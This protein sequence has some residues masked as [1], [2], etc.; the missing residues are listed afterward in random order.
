MSEPLSL[1]DLRRKTAIHSVNG[2][3]ETIVIMGL[4]A[5]D[6]C[7]IIDRFQGIGLLSLGGRVN[8]FEALREV[9]SALAAWTAAAC[10]MGGSKEAEQHVLDN[11]T[12]DQAMGIVEASMPLTFVHGG[13]GPFYDRQMAVL[14]LLFPPRGKGQAMTS[15]EQSSLVADPLTPAFG[16]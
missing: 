4:T 5:K 16:S 6:Y 8:I 9:P 7:S 3:D 10:G 11:L 12:V 2:G 14:A 13:F 1:M 15:P